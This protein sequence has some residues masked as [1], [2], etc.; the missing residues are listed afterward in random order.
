MLFNHS[1]KDQTSKKIFIDNVP[2]DTKS[3]TKIKPTVYFTCKF[4]PTLFTSDL[5][6]SLVIEHGIALSR[7]SHYLK[8]GF[9][10]NVVNTY[11]RAG[12]KKQ[13][14]VEFPY[15]E[16]YYGNWDFKAGDIIFVMAHEMCYINN[17]NCITMIT[18]KSVTDI[19]AISKED[20]DNE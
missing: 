12:L 7:V 9:T 8:K 2:V 17:P 1:N 18:I 20:E 5:E 15:S 16:S 13:L 11:M 19:N 10:H 3:K 6:Y 14:G 4:L